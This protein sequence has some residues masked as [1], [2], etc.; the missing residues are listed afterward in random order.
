[1][2]SLYEG[3]GCF[4][5]ETLSHSDSTLGRKCHPF[6]CCLH[7]V[8]IMFKGVRVYGLLVR[9]IIPTP[10]GVLTMAQTKLHDSNCVNCIKILP[11]QAV[12]LGH[13]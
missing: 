5:A 6:K 7:S 2:M 8:T 9:L 10:D 13:L 4:K 3:N 1:M 11:K 12:D